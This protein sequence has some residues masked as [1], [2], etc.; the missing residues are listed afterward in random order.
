ME[1]NFKSTLD[2]WLADAQRMVT[3]RN[4]RSFP[5]LKPS[6]LS[7]DPNGRKYVRIVIE[8]QSGTSRS[9]YCF[10]DSTNGNILKADGWKKPAK[11]PR[12]NI[13]APNPLEGVTEYGAVYAR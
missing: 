8:A 2:A 12:G 1:T 11:G 6:T 5:T 9:V 3:E 4:L 10:I 13:Y 7:I